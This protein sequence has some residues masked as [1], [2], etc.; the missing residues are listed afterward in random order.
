[1]TSLTMLPRSTAW[2][3]D[4]SGS[5]K[6]EGGGHTLSWKMEPD[7]DACGRKRRGGDEGAGEAV[8]TNGES[9]RCIYGCAWG[10]DGGGLAL[11]PLGPCEMC[12]VAKG[13]AKGSSW[14]L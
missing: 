1:M 7:S 13:V 14:S 10:K 9:G 8:R 2:E 3:G 11:P 12:V 4:V 6:C 5:V